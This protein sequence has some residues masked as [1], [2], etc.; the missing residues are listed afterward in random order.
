MQPQEKAIFMILYSRQDINQAY[1]VAAVD[2]LHTN[3]L[4]HGSV[5]S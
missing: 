5:A 4:N 2:V 3:A 1:I